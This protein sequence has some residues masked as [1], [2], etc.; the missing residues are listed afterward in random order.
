MLSTQLR[1]NPSPV[2][3]GKPATL[4]LRVRDA[5]GQPVPTLDLSHG[6]PMHLFLISKDLRSFAHVHPEAREG[7]F[8]LEHTF[9]SGGEYMVLVDYARPGGSAPVDRHPLRVEGPSRPS[10]ALAVTPATQRSDGLVFTLH[11]GDAARA[12]AGGAHLHFAIADAAT[13]RPVDDLEPYLEA[14]AHFAVLSEDGKDFLHVHPLD[15]K[16]GQ[17]VAAHAVFPRA[18]LYKL[19][20]QVQRQGRVV[21]VPFVLRVQPADASGPVGVPGHGAHGSHH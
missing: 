5:R 4:A 21:T 16:P 15:S 20:V 2:Q 6:K 10:T 1:S 12:G 8:A 18:G 17:G 13:G 3:A 9:E 14:M 19:W 11:G 7:E